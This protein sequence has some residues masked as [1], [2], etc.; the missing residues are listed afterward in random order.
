MFGKGALIMVMGAV[1]IFSLYQLRLNRSVLSTTDNFNRQ[2]IKTKISA[3]SQSAMN[4]ALN[5]VLNSGS[6]D[7]TY[8][9]YSHNCT[10]LVKIK[11]LSGGD[12]VRTSVVSSGWVIDEYDNSKFRRAQDS[13]VALFTNEVS[14]SQYGWW[15]DDENGVFWITGDTCWGRM[16]SNS[17]IHTKGSPVF[18]KKLTSSLGIN[19]SV[20]TSSA[21]FN[22]GYEK[23]DKV[24]MPTNMSKLETMATSGNGGASVN[25]KCLYDQDL[26]LDFLADGRVGRTTGGVTDTV[27]LTD[28]AP[29]GVIWNTGETR[30]KGTLNGQLS[31][32]S[33]DIYIDDDVVMADNP[34]TNPMSDDALGLISRDDIFVTNNTANNSDCVIQAGICAVDG[35]FQAEDPSSRPKAG[36]LTI[37]GSIAQKKRGAVGKFNPT[38][39]VIVNGFQK[40]YYHDKRFDPDY[41]EDPNV[42]YIYPPGYPTLSGSGLSLVYWWE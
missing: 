21:I 40:N 39:K 27:L 24:P 35:S 34:M 31:I 29:T 3:A 38:T 14:M 22:G 18:M 2:Y 8:F 42:N 26:E 15:S 19:P 20:K 7:K 13:V 37:Y 16:H 11:Q 33:E 10:S 12:S 36:S 25:T 30:V 41:K 9:I 5:D 28:I 23:I 17:M 6:T 1:I 32:L 4:Y